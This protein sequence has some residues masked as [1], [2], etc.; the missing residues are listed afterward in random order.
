MIRSRLELADALSVVEM[1]RKDHAEK[2][3]VTERRQAELEGAVRAAD[4]VCPLCFTRTRL[5]HRIV[6]SCK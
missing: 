3:S 5:S 6:Q 4:E 2:L 1:E